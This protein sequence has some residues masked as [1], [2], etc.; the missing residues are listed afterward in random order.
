[1]D[2]KGVLVGTQLFD[3]KV[4]VQLPES[5]EG[6]LQVWD[7]ANSNGSEDTD[8]SILITTRWGYVFKTNWTTRTTFVT[9]NL[10]NGLGSHEFLDLENDG[11]PE[12]LCAGDTY[13]VCSITGEALWSK[14]ANTSSYQ[15]NLGAGD[16]DG[17]GLLEVYIGFSN[18]LFCYNSSGVE[19][20]RVGED[21]FYEEVV[22]GENVPKGFSQV[23]ASVARGPVPATSDIYLE[24]RE[25]DGRL[26]HS[27]VVPHA[28]RN[29]TLVPWL[30]GENSYSLLAKTGGAT[31]VFLDLHGRET[32]RFTPPS[33]E[34]TAQGLKASVI[35]LGPAGE[36][37]PFLA[38]LLP[39][40]VEWDRASL[41]LFSTSNEL[42]YH[43]II[44][45]GNGLLATRDPSTNEPVLLASDGVDTI[46]IY[47]FAPELSTSIPK[48]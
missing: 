16:L 26:S 10:E 30:A 17:D 9:G 41:L 44:G 3:K 20:W 35:Q 24:F 13:G 4:F 22:N 45:Q 29:F 14:V 33:R 48:P 31:V 40:A 46:S 15:T 11:Q 38:I 32:F 2:E 5:I 7:I 6:P 25:A 39:Y 28:Y 19:L 42:V 34:W 21:D 23:I 12:L 37:K 43:E 8:D 18:G 47:R 1:M 27:F 36:E